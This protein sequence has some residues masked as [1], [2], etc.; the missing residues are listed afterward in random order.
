[1]KRQFIQYLRVARWTAWSNQRQSDRRTRACTN[2]WWRTTVGCVR[3]RP[4]DDVSVC[5]WVCVCMLMMMRCRVEQVVVAAVGTARQADSHSYSRY[6]DDDDYYYYSCN[7]WYM[8][9]FRTSYRDFECVDKT[10]T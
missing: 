8:Y 9:V 1:M 4:C 7:V 5:V 3:A 6:I 2:C 10:S